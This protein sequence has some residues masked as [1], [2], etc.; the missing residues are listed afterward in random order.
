MADVE[1]DVNELRRVFNQQLLLLLTDLQRRDDNLQEDLEAIL[2]NEVGVLR[3]AAHCGNDL[4]GTFDIGVNI[5]IL[6]NLL[7]VWQF[8]DLFD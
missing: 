4:D 6:N 8:Q 7:I 5:A 2:Q 3:L 1:R